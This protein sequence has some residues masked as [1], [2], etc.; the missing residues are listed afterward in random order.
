MK[1]FWDERYGSKEYAYGTEPNE[2]YKTQL[3]SLTPGKILLTAEGEGRN[4]V[5]ATT[6]GWDVTAY[7]INTEGRKKAE[8]LA[9]KKGV[10]INYTM[11]SHEQFTTELET[12]DCIVLIF[13]HSAPDNRQ[14]IHKKLSGLLKPGGRIILEAFSKQQINNNFGGPRNVEMLFSEEDLKADFSG[15]STLNISE[16]TIELYEGDF[17]KGTA[18]VIRMVGEK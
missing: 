16:E 8:L 15:F 11:A 10:K 18:S 3:S 2:F 4:A 17:H 14:I 6:L 7:D 9:M 5:Y 1:E 13:V 12:Y